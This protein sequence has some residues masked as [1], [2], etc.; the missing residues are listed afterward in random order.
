MIAMN[1]KEHKAPNEPD[2]IG[3]AQEALQRAQ[4]YLR[5]GQNADSPPMTGRELFE[6]IGMIAVGW[7]AGGLIGVL[8]RFAAKM[9]LP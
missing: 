7:A 2:T 8:L 9:V 3:T 4:T 6:L 1:L 5:V